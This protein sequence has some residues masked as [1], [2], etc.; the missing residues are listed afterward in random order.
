MSDDRDQFF[1]SLFGPR[2]DFS[3]QL[4]YENRTI[5]R[6]INECGVKPRSW[7]KLVNICRDDT[8]HPFF[9]FGWFNNFFSQ[10]PAVLSGKRIGYCGTKVDDAGERKKVCLYQLT[11]ADIFKPQKNLLVRAISTALGDAGV[12]SSRPFIFVFPVVRKMFCAHNL[13]VE[14]H[15]AQVR[16]QWQFRHEGATMFVEPSATLFTAIGGDWY[17]D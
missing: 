4:S 3:R 14:S 5:K 11:V 6:V 17:Q 16:V 1:N 8:G 12:D 15:D 13:H 7:G 2:D 10:F 9:S